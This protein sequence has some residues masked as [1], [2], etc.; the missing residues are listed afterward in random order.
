LFRWSEQLSDFSRLHAKAIAIA[1][2][3][4]LYVGVRLVLLSADPPLELPNGRSGIEL[5]VEGA[6]KA[7]EARNRAL[8]HRWKTHRDDN[9]QFWRA[10]SPVWVYPL[11]WTFRAFGVGH[12]Q[13]RVFSILTSAIGL[14]GV[15]LI[16][17]RR[18][19]GATFLVAGVFLALNYYYLFY[20]RA[21]LL[22]PLVNGFL[23]LAVFCLA[24]SLRSLWWLAGAVAFFLLAF[25]SK[26]TGVVLA[27]TLLI[28]SVWSLVTAVR[29]RRPARQIAIPLAA[30]A[31][32]MICAGI[33][34]C[35][36]QY[37][38]S[39]SWNLGHALYDRP[40]A[41]LDLSGG[42]LA[43]VVDRL[44]DGARWYEGVFLLMPAALALAVIGCVRIG[45]RAFE[46]RAIDASDLLVTLWFASA[47]GSLL[48]TPL[49][50]VRFC[51]LLFPPAALLAAEGVAAAAEA[52]QQLPVRAVVVASLL[53][54]MTAAD[55]VAW[56]F[57]AKEPQYVIRDT[58]DAI[59]EKIGRQRAVIVGAWAPPVLL[60]TRY[61]NYYVKHG[62]FNTSKKT[63]KKLGITHILK[64]GH[65]DWTWDYVER[66]VPD[67]GKRV[68]LLA[69][70]RLWG[71]MPAKL[72][73]VTTPLDRPLEK[74]PKKGAKR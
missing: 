6:A 7:Q 15:M 59:S 40:R 11:S 29:A 62:N 30:C 52:V 46:S 53:G 50:D 49:E 68:K 48:L 66:A 27:P 8:F 54:A 61:R 18:F 10:Q 44:R 25:F 51:L 34:V 13:L 31:A 5:Y 74:K 4:G 33:Y 67:V 35:K 72:L 24:L 1:L 58:A 47:L 42:A 23:S 56:A 63:V 3:L 39:V 19:R 2:V 9:Y 36:D 26:Q 37:L 28:F 55:V 60:G 12:A 71:G 43:S 38:R 64:I 16:A 45:R 20:T 70:Y 14:L 65:E 32:L 41:E 73:A 21:G 17:A 69:R 57:W 22:E